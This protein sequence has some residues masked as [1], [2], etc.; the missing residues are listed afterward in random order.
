M[1]APVYVTKWDLYQVPAEDYRSHYESIIKE[2]FK[3]EAQLPNVLGT[4]KD[5]QEHP[6]WRPPSFYQR[7]EHKASIRDRRIKKLTLFVFLSNFFIA[8]FWMPFWSL[9]EERAFS[10]VIFLYFAAIL[11]I[12]ILGSYMREKQSIYKSLLDTILLGGAWFGGLLCAKLYTSV[13]NEMFYALYV[14]VMTFSIFLNGAFFLG[15]IPV[16]KKNKRSMTH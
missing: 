4:T 12:Y 16:S 3:D 5:H 9:D 8:L 1:K 15:R 6:V 7:Q 2:P 11:M 14:N 13:P 10:N